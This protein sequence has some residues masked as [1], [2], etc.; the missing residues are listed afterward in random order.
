MKKFLNI[1]LLSRIMQ[2]IKENR[3]LVCKLLFQILLTPHTLLLKSVVFQ[4]FFIYFYFLNE[5]HMIETEILN[6][7]NKTMSVVFP[8]WRGKSD[9]RVG[10]VF[11]DLF[12]TSPNETIERVHVRSLLCS[13]LPPSGHFLLWLRCARIVVPQQTQR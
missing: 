7:A 13:S 4:I 1:T 5:H 8:F 6:L 2:G 12:S 11:K 10:S 3:N 9:L